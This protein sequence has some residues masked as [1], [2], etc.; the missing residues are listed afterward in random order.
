MTKLTFIGAG[1]LGFTRGL[2]RDVL[3]FPLLRDAE[4]CLMDIN[5]ERLDF[6][7]KAVTKIIAAG[8]YPA[9]ERFR[10][11]IDSKLLCAFEV[12]SRCCKLPSRLASRALR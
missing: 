9:K 10:R 2:V 1:S 8:G 5:A 3:T 12:L 4:I 11:R 7:L 6:A